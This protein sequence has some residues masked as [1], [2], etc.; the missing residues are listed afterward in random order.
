MDFKV[1]FDGTYLKMNHIEQTH[2]GKVFCL[3]YQD[4]GNYYL[5]FIDNSGQ[6][7]DSIHLNPELGID[8][9]SLPL[10]GFWEPLITAAFLPDD[11]AF[12]A[13]YHRKLRKQFHFMYSYLEKKIISPISEIIIADAS[14]LNFPVKSFYSEVTGNCLTFYR[15]GYLIS[16]SAEDLA[17]PQLERITTADLGSMYLLFDQALIVRSSSSILFFKIDPETNLWA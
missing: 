12:I 7:L 2:S 6:T 5:S 3:A 16:E 1:E 11:R 13:V 9:S 4:N 8:T 14:F 10:T 15:Q 17:S